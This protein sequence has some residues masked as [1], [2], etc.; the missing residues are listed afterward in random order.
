M[1]LNCYRYN[2]VHL[3]NDGITVTEDTITIEW[4]GTGPGANVIPL[5]FQCKLHGVTRYHQCM[6]AIILVSLYIY[7]YV[8]VISI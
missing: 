7:L 3:I 2:R 6:S 1:L 4:Q 5:P 8:Y